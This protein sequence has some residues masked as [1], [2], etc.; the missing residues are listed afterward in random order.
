M[1]MFSFAPA[2]ST[3]V[4]FASIASAGSF[5]LFSENGVAGLPTVTSASPEPFGAAPAIV[6]NPR[7]V[8]TGPS[9]M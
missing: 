1:S 6:A 5:C 4:W 8:A 3:F 9:V 2:T 7:I